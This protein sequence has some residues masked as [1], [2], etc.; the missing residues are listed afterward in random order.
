[1]HRSLFVVLVREMSGVFGLGD[2]SCLPVC[3]D[4]AII[5]IK[6]RVAALL[7][8]F[9]SIDILRGFCKIGSKPAQIATH[10]WRRISFSM[11]EERDMRV[12]RLH[13]LR[14]RGV[15]PYPNRVMRSHTIAEALQ[16]FEEWQGEEQ[17]LT[18]V[19]RIRL[20]RDMGKAAFVHIE[21]GTGRIQVYFRI[22]DLGEEAFKVV[23][24]LDI[25]DFVQVSGFLFLTR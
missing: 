8:R 4:S 17:T 10:F 6:R 13:A 1:A 15:N 7:K 22:N 12:Q 19:G 2:Y 9:L 21:D 5:A 16:H 18:L 24:A 20:L 23:K 14:E 3:K 25:G 11:T